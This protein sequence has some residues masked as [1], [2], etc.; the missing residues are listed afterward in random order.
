MPNEPQRDMEEKLKAYAGARRQE[1]GGPFQLHPA[2]RKMLLDE[3]G[4]AFP[5]PATKESKPV[6]FAAWARWA[7]GSAV[8]AT[9][10]FV[11]TLVHLNHSHRQRE[12]V[13]LLTDSE[14]KR[15]DQETEALNQT[16]STVMLALDDAITARSRSKPQPTI[17]LATNGALLAGGPSEAARFDNLAV[18][19]TPLPPSAP[20]PA[21]APYNNYGREVRLGA[22]L[23]AVQDARTGQASKESVNGKDSGLKREGTVAGVS[24]GGDLPAPKEATIAQ[25]RPLTAQPANPASGPARGGRKAGAA[26]DFGAFGGGAGGAGLATQDPKS[27]LA[28]A[29]SLARADASAATAG[30]L[31]PSLSKLTVSPA[32]QQ[33]RSYGLGENKMEA[34]T[35]PATSTTPLQQQ[36]ANSRRDGTEVAAVQY[37]FAL[38]PESADRRSPEGERGALDAD[39]A[40]LAEAQVERVRFAQLD[41]R[42]QYRNNLNSPPLPNILRQFDVEIE[43]DRV[44]LTDTDGSVYEGRMAPAKDN[45]GDLAGVAIEKESR[46]L[47]AESAGRRGVELERPSAVVERKLALAEKDAKGTTAAREIQFQATGI[48]RRLNQSVVFKGSLILTARNSQDDEVDRLT[49]NEG[50]SVSKKLNDESLARSA[51]ASMGAPAPKQGDYK[52]RGDTYRELG[53]RSTLNRGGSVLR[54]QGR[55]KVGGRDEFEVQAVPSPAR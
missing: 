36:A 27:E 45:L 13:A 53:E 20:A 46:A 54:V 7:F 50:D 40:K 10:A 3:V 47:K 55:A 42:K 28:Q 5:P 31:A 12:T 33:T 17:P 38:Q 26:P 6:W 2:T 32:Q 37:N 44:R 34:P 22:E 11:A 52:S 1:A 8:L 49:R 24:R 14:S 19:T 29:R 9:T 30:N 4:R 21:P 39:K 25:N 23:E 16:A 51:K 15:T 35:P 41:V 43:G 18:L 48:N